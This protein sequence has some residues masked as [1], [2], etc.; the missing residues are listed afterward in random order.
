MNANTPRVLFFRALLIGICLF[1]GGIGISRAAEISNTAVVKEAGQTSWI[2]EGQ[3]KH[4][5]YVIFDPNC[6]YCHKVFDD[7]QSY[8][9]HY[10]FRWI[11]VAI[12]TPTSAGKA[13]AMLQADNPN[14]ALQKNENHFVR[15]RGKGGGLK[16]LA[17][18]TR[19]TRNELSKNQR[20]LKKTGMEVV[21]TILFL[22][23]NGKVEVIKG[24]PSKADFPSILTHVAVLHSMN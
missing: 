4:V 3:G 8:L 6:P 5:V 13:A 22:K 10:Q 2:A 19:K 14:K 9:K 7:S 16:P 23:K 18:M 11:P 17:H 15:M 20:L 24:A 21:P 1:L 12:L